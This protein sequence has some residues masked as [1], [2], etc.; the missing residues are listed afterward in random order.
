MD[1]IGIIG[2]G[3]MGAAMALRYAGQSVPVTGWTRSARAVD[4]VPYAP[5]LAGLVAASDVLILSL[6]DDAAVAETLDRL[7][8][9]DLAGKLVIDTSTVAP[10]VM[11]SRAGRFAAL[12]A[13]L[14]D[15]PISGGPELVAAGACGIFIGTDTDTVARAQQA[16]TPLSNRIF[17]VGELGTGLAMKTVNNALLQTYFAGLAEQM[18]V[19]KRAGLDLQTA[20]TILCGGPAGVP[21]VRDRVPKI[22]GQDPT[23]GFTVAGIAKDNAV[24]QR[25]ASE[26]GVDTPTLRAAQ[27][28]IADGMATGLADADPAAL[29][30]QAYHDA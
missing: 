21:M 11:K 17:H 18:R 10:S 29:I 13:A 28:M 5:D 2:L 7:V 9:H 3:R 6:F 14:A 15:A 22:L 24:F 8:G 23:V 4:G 20:L 16:L 19:A 1:R 30:A 27:A 26:L 25:V 12:G